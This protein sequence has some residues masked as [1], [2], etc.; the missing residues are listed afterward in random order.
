MFKIVQMKVESNNVEA[1]TNALPFAKRMLGEVGSPFTEQE[2]RIMK[3]IVEAHNEFVK[4]ERGHS[5]EIQEWVSGVHQ[6]QSILS[7]RCLRR[8]FPSHFS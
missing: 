3:L 7:H 1:S 2:Q 6:L 4:L 5:M 8:L